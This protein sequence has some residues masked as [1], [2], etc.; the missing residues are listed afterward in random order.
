M[1]SFFSSKFLFYLKYILIYLVGEKKIATVKKGKYDSNNHLIWIFHHLLSTLTTSLQFKNDKWPHYQPLNT[2]CDRANYMQDIWPS[3]SL[4]HSPRI[5]VLLTPG[6]KGERGRRRRGHI[7]LN[8][9]ARVSCSFRRALKSKKNNRARFCCDCQNS[10]M[11]WKTGNEQ[12]SSFLPV[13][14]CL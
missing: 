10:P 6:E 7:W 12:Y 13:H 2:M 9:T 1:Q 14:L 4:Q 5:R 11:P 3:L 8:L